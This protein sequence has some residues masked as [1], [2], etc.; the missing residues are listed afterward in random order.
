M[1]AYTAMTDT[2]RLA[3][4]WRDLALVTFGEVLDDMLEASPRARDSHAART[5]VVPGGTPDHDFETWDR[6]PV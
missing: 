6:L 5:P 4:D 2:A 1:N 3:L